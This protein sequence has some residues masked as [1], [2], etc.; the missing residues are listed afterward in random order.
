MRCHGF[1]NTRAR[2]FYSNLGHNSETFCN[3]MAL[4]HL[5]NGVQFALGDLAAD[6]RPSAQVDNAYAQPLPAGF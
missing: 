3:P 2:I 1:V 4:Q 6:A 5:L